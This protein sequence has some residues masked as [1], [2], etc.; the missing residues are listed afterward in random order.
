MKEREKEGGREGEGERTFIT[1]YQLH[2]IIKY[3][4]NNSRLTY[5]CSNVHVH[6]MQAYMYM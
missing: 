5:K 4:H 3:M 1:V 2:V 6:Y